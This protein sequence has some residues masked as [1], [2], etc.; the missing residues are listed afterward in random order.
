MP[1]RLTTRLPK[2]LVIED[3]DAIRRMLAR[4][5]RSWGCLVRGAA[6]ASEGIA[7][8]YELQ[9]DLVVSDLQLGDASGV[10][11]LKE[12]CTATRGTAVL[13]VSGA[14]PPVSLPGSVVGYLQKPFDPLALVQKV[15]RQLGRAGHSHPP[16]PQG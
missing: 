2:I 9:P 14:E 12:L 7:L 15:K 16:D 1:T 6:G 8:A 5:L 10:E 11:W 4:T 3:D 13:V